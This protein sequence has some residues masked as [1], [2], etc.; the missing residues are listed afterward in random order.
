MLRVRLFFCCC[1]FYTCQ[2]LQAQYQSLLHKS[3]A[4]RRP[5]LRNFYT[6]ELNS[7]APNYQ[8]SQKKV[9]EIKVLALENND[10]DLEL[11]VSLMQ[12]H[13]DDRFKRRDKKQIIFSLDSLNEIAERENLKWL[14]CRAQSYA[15]LC[16]FC[17]AYNYELAFNYAEQL[18]L[19]LQA[20]TKEEFPEKQICYS[21]LGDFYYHFHDWVT[22]L[23]YFELGLKETP[24]KFRDQWQKLCCN[25]IGLI[26]EKK[27]QYDTAIFYYKRALQS[28]WENEQGK[29]VWVGILNGNL[30]NCFYYKKRFAEARP[31]L[32]SAIDSCLK[33]QCLGIVSDAYLTLGMISIDENNL[34]EANQN[35]TLSR[36]YASDVRE[37]HRLEKL[38]P[39]LAKLAQKEGDAAK[40]SRYL[41]SAL[42]VKDSMA[43]KMNALY[44]LRGT[45]KASLLKEQKL[46]DDKRLKTTQRNFLIVIVL[47][48]MAVAIYI[49][50]LQRKR[51]KQKRL[52]H[53]M[54]LQHNQKE[55]AMATEQLNEFAKTISEK[56][57]LVDELEKKL[58]SSPDIEMISR[59]R[60]STI[61]TD[62]EW[63]HF[64]KLFEQVHKGYMIR[65]KEKL[66]D[67][68][69]AEIRFMVLAK[70]KFNNK[71]MA[72]A[73]NISS[74]AIRTT[75]YRLRKK[76]NLPE[77]GSLE[78]L[79]DSI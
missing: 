70:L 14:K 4:A 56:N 74:Q 34:A 40:M 60:E 18:S 13:V 25:S 19:S 77:E 72:N 44:I 7:D 35:L 2:T 22:A 62:E 23:R 38:Y 64:R 21:Q 32:H 26:Y 67:L 6:D 45:Q 47:I 51:F 8:R 73:L 27:Q 53:E 69:Q 28:I 3:Y 5:E 57:R 68:T 29:E 33:Y 10:R 54:Q 66:P 39:V 55:L 63:D 37:Y 41:D 42:V 58:G 36:F 50:Y 76:I 30:G 61:L 15:A 59:L 49:F 43:R 20:V 12:I 31:M 16:G 46:E 1:L 71:E 79:V 75:W 17:D 9:N 11:E 48:L 78:E 24:D 65:L 52:I